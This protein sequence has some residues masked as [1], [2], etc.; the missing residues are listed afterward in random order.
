[1]RHHRQIAVVL[2]LVS[3]LV[4]I[5]ATGGCTNSSSSQSKAKKT[6]GKRVSQ[7]S[8]EA[9]Q[10]RL[11]TA[12]ISVF[13][14]QAQC[15]RVYGKVTNTSKKTAIMIKIRVLEGTEKQVGITSIENLRPNEEKTFEVQTAVLESEFENPTLEISEVWE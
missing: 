9:W 14:N 6:T 12:I 5:F 8:L 2:L 1:M 13:P 7:E 3:A 15:A 4:V 10:K 11:P